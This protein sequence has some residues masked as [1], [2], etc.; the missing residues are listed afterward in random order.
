MP[1]IIAPHPQSITLPPQPKDNRNET[2]CQKAK[3]AITP[4]D[5]ESG[6]H[7]RRKKRES[8]TEARTE[9]VVTGG[10]GS[11]IGR[12]SWNGYDVFIKDY[13]WGSNSNHLNNAQV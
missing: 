3:Q 2:D 8:R 4:V 7:L 9:E 5:T 6:E 10:D 11:E 13:Q 1:R 12:R